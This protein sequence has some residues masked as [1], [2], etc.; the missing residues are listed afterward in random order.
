MSYTRPYESGCYIYSDEE[1][2]HFNL[3]EIPEDDI[4]IFLYKLYK[5]RRKEFK[6]RLKKGKHL[7]IQNTKLMKEKEE[8]YESM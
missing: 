7:I 3:K 1:N 2:L 8:K 6:Q 4:N 5:T